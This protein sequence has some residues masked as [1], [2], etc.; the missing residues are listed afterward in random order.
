MMA[1]LTYLGTDEVTLLSGGSYYVNSIFP[2]ENG[3]L[4][5]DK[6]FEDELVIH[7]LRMPRT[8]TPDRVF[9]HASYFMERDARPVPIKTDHAVKTS[10]KVLMYL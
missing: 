9:S 5:M 7:S 10:N 4:D 3:T 2:H 1:E 8:V 6:I